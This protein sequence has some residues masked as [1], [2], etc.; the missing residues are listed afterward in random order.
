MRKEF[1]YE[2]IAEFLRKNILE[3]RYKPGEK[4]PTIREM[5]QIWNCTSGTIQRAYLEL[6]SQGLITSHPGRGTHVVDLNKSDPLALRQNGLI[7]RVENFLGENINL[8]YLPAEIEKAVS[9][10]IQKYK[11]EKADIGIPHGKTLRFIGSH[12][13]ALEWMSSHFKEIIPDVSFSVRFKGSLGGLFALADGSADLTGCHL[14]DDKSDTYNI[15]YIQKIFPGEGIA[16]MTLSHRRLGLI[17]QAGN[18]LNIIS[19]ADLIKPGLV[20][21]NRQMGSGTRVW[22]DAK[23]SGLGIETLKIIGYNNEKNTHLDVAQVVASG[24]GNVGLGLEAAALRYG[25]SFIPLTLERYDLIFRTNKFDGSML[26]TLQ[27]WLKQE[28]TRE[29]IVNLGGYETHDTGT[30]T[31][32]N[33]VAGYKNAPP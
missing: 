8:G 24:S 33:P 26:L 18:P 1:Y 20:F 13:L 22:L 11:S 28:S 30:I 23:L 31:W 19:L 32:T 14:W 10:G 4:L 2:Q 25:L 27:N 6:A 29:N 17:L 12:D 21:V 7:H 9:I 5:R 16:C 3:G 15:P